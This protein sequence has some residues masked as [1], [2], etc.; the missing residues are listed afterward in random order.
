MKTFVQLMAHQMIHAS[1]VDLIALKE[2][3]KLKLMKTKI[4][5]IILSVVAIISFTALTSN[6]ESKSDNK[7]SQAYQSSGGQTMTDP[8][9]FD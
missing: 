6:N 2:T 9:Q 3:T 1:S 4:F 5:V 8:H 7:D